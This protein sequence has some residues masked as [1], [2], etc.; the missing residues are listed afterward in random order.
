MSEGYDGMTEMIPKSYGYNQKAFLELYLIRCLIK[1][2]FKIIFWIF[3]AV[4][5]E[6]KSL[7]G[8]KHLS[9]IKD[10]KTNC[11]SDA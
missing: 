10:W 5:Y 2:Y 7:L 4:K 9:Y 8:W 1:L 11:L 3:L 6:K